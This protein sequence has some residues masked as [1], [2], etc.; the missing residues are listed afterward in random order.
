MMACAWSTTLDLAYVVNW[1]LAGGPRRVMWALMAAGRALD[2]IFWQ[3]M[4]G[5][6]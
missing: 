3:P 5:G 2:R 1:R 4:W 6:S